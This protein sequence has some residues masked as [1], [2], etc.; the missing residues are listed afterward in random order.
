MEGAQNWK[1]RGSKLEKAEPSS[2]NSTAELCDQICSETYKSNQNLPEENIPEW[3]TL[4][5]G[6]IIDILVIK[7][8]SLV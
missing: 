7:A 4:A 3:V 8:T 6:Q 2:L 1:N 5:K